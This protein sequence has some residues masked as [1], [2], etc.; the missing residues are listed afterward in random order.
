[1]QIAERNREIVRLFRADKTLE[2]IGEKYGITRERVRQIVKRAGEKTRREQAKSIRANIVDCAANNV[3]VAEISTSMAIKKDAVYR[4]LRSAGVRANREVPG[5]L[6]DDIVARA[7]LVRKGLSIR[8]A[9]GGDRRIE[10]KLGR[11]CA[12]HNIETKHGRWIERKERLEL[13]ATLRAAG[14]TWIEV[15]KAVSDLEGKPI[16]SQALY[17]WYIARIPQKST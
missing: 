15:A 5:Y 3:S 14:V 8:A 11:Y 4:T 9:S 2:S 6:S 16:K 13:I 12:I 1:M 7:D 10:A 17:N